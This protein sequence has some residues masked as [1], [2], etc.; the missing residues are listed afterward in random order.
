[1]CLSVLR[2]R[3]S[4]R[5]AAGL[6]IAMLSCSATAQRS[7]AAEHRNTAATARTQTAAPSGILTSMSF[8]EVTDQAGL[9]GSLRSIAAGTRYGVMQGGGAVGDFNND[10]YHDIFVLAGGGLNDYLYINNTDGTFS[11]QAAPWG[12]DRKHHSFGASAA[13]FNNDGYLDLFVTSYGDATFAPDSG[14]LI[15]YQN[16][17]PDTNGQWS[18]T[19]VAVFCGV[20]R[21]Y[22]ETRDGTGSGWG[23]YDL[24]GDL[25]LV[26]AG[27]NESRP[28][29]RLFRNNG[30]QSNYTFTD[31]TAEA[32]IEF[33]Y[34][35][36]FIPHFVDMNNDRYPEL[37]MVSDTGRSRYFV[38]NADGTFSDRSNIVNGLA[39]ASAMGVDVADINNDGL[40]DMYISSINFTDTN[41][42]GNVLLIQN[43]DGSY[44]NTARDNGTHAGYWGWGVLMNDFDHDRDIDIAETNGYVGAYNT[45]PAVLFENLGDGNTFNEVAQQAG[46]THNGQGRGLARID[47]ENDGDLDLVVFENVGKLR[48]Y[49]NNLIDADTP[50]DRNWIRITLGTAANDALAP[51]GIGAMI[52]LISDGQSQIRP[53]HCGANHA[54]SSP[55]EVH[56]GFQ[57][58][59]SIDI[60]Q[61]R[62]PDGSF[63]TL[64][65]IA[66]NQLLHINARAT[67]VDYV[68]DGLSDIHDVLAFVDLY[69]NSNLL[70]DRNGDLQLNF[71]DVAAFI[72]DF[73]DIIA[74]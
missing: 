12:L 47:L 61:V 57:D 54:S 22:G 63:T 15:L 5:A 71:F 24:D 50:D 45:D 8:V 4:C 56:A 62:W 13:D 27:Y 19:D 65:N 64:E 69:Q 6:A 20:N 29:N 66:T 48:V 32:G 25:D 1:M 33:T 3:L 21:L 40:L 17:G 68:G 51:D 55:I 38:N 58:Q 31:V 44:N 41:G 30:P 67:S 23:D 18:F 7:A 34:M 39:T 42:P 28:C 9:G 53:M 10:G 35:P 11:E 36:G 59:Q 49:K 70:A 73:L 14:R 72:E 46:F 60:V 74:P 2:S 16:N 26:V 43:P 52:T 37:L